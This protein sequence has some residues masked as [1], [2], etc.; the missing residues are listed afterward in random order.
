MASLLGAGNFKPAETNTKTSTFV[1]LSQTK[2][3]VTMQ[4]EGYNPQVYV[5]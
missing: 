4:I 1:G 3:T 2:L 5:E